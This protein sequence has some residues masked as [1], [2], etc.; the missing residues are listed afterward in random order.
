MKLGLARAMLQ[1]ADLLL[2]DEPT[3][4]LDV[5]HVDWLVDYLQG[6]Q[7]EKEQ[8]VTTIIVSHSP[9]F[10]DRVCTHIIHVQDQ[11]LKVFPGNFSQFKVQVPEAQLGSAIG[12]E[13]MPVSVFKLPEP[14]PLEGVN[15]RGKRFLCLE[16]V[17]YTYPNTA[18]PAVFGVNVE[19][20]LN[21]RV[22]LVGPN[23]AGK[24]T[25]AGLL[26][27]ELAVDSGSAWRHPNLR[28]VLVAQHAFHHL[29]QH[30]DLTATQYILW[31]FEGNEDREALDF[32][33]DDAEVD[34]VRTY[35]LLAGKLV[36]C[37]AE[38]EDDVAEPEAVLD[39][40][41]RG[42]FGYEY[43]V[44]WRGTRSDTRTTSWVPRWQLIAMGHIGIAKREDA[45]QAAL[46]SL[47]G[48]P[49]TTPGVEA[50]LAGFGLDA[51]EASHRRLGALSNGQRARAVLGAA[52]W[53]APHLLVLDEPSNYLDQPALAALAAG[54]QNFG[55]GV[56][57]ISH[58]SALLEEVCSSQWLMESGRLRL[59]SD[60]SSSQNDAGDAPTKVNSNAAREAKEIAIQKKKAKRLKE[61]RRKKGEEV[62]EDEDWWEDLLKKTNHKS[63]VSRL[64]EAC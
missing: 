37:E 36:A 40:R 47:I 8:Q 16:N 23:G 14:G 15:S 21:S 62:S 45:R 11:K 58:N 46:H 35:K 32:M 27:G 1:A 33:A 22:A 61:L 44:R 7:A 52:T 49:L 59:R 13:A 51:E 9:Q 41:Q 31:R 48:R 56:V 50:H 20:S 6:L 64:V 39:R 63:E 53:L 30:T 54:L 26:V 57:V 55:G 17:F 24:S 12:D 2:L 10:L 60:N 29:E 28:I 42:R 18:R 19:C 34:Q 43:E 3:G 25:L 4:H 5:A 38:D